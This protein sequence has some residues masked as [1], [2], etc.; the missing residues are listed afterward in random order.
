MDNLKSIIEN[1]GALILPTETVYG[2]FAR[3][4]DEQAVNKVYALKQR[5]REKAMNLNVADYQAILDY[6]KDQPAYLKELYDAFLPGPLTII[7]KANDRVPFWINSGKDTVGFRLPKHP[8]T[9]Q[10]IRL[11]GPL[12]GPSANLS[13]SQSGRHYAD[14]IRAFHNQVEGYEDDQFLTGEDS[15]IIDLSGSKAKILRQGSISAAHIQAKISRI[16]FE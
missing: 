11:A 6:S 10:L 9:A 1:G 4:M 16:V 3:A 15:T 13:G 14:I 5:P 12:I 7:L 8:V 2:L